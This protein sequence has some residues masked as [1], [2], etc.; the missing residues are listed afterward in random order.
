V[1]CFFFGAPGLTVKSIRIGLSDSPTLQ[2]P[3]EAGNRFGPYEIISLLGV[4]GM[5]EVY[6]ARDTRLDRVVAVK[7]LRAHLASDLGRRARF[8]R[9]ARTNSQLNQPHSGERSRWRRLTPSARAPPAESSRSP[10]V[11]CRDRPRRN[12]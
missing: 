12:H 8:E 11:T 3:M 5:G 1:N 9:E 10:N 7:V 4:R 2:A 6:R